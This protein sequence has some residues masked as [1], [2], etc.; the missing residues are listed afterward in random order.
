MKF[1]I[2]IINYFSFLIINVIFYSGFFHN[3]FDYTSYTNKVLISHII[4]LSIINL[5]FKSILEVKIIKYFFKTLNILVILF[6]TL[7]FIT[8]IIAFLL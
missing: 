3:I 2:L 6:T 8:T 5:K 1:N 4:I 7:I